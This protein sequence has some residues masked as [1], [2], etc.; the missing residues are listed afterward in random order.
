MNKKLVEDIRRNWADKSNDELIQIWKENDHEKWSESALEAAKQILT[1]RGIAIPSQH[2][3]KQAKTQ[4]A[5]WSKMKKLKV[6]AVITIIAGLILW[7]EL[8]RVETERQK[9]IVNSVR[10]LI[11]E[12]KNVGDISISILGKCLVWD[13]TKNSR[14]DAHAKLSRELRAS[15]SDNQITVFMVMPERNVLVGHYSISGEPGY[16]QYVDV[17]VA[18]WPEKRAVGMHSVVSKEPAS[19]RP[20][21]D[22]PEYGDSS[23][24]IARWIN[25]LP[26]MK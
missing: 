26:R 23:E 20:V 24:K 13:M 6:I 19:S 3:S 4:A 15:S 18:Y 14:S 5:P 16:R 7:G 17:L 9:E 11:H 12:C 22:V 1:E 8:S 21:Q 25:S 2:P 10:P